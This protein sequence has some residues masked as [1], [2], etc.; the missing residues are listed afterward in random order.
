MMTKT[1]MGFCGYRCDFCP[2]YEKNIDRLTS[3]KTLRAGWK[4]Y[5]GF[6]VP[7][8]RIICVGC[9]VQGRHLDTDCPVQPC[10]LEK[11]LDNCSCCSSFDSCDTLR[12]R[13]DIVDELKN[14]F[15]GMISEEEYDLFFRPYEGR[16]ELKKQ[17]KK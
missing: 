9:R 1:H 5:F 12:S 15:A 3:R 16:T 17:N 4:K 10:A 8:E 7:E 6:D 13:A 14:K 2:A 11:H